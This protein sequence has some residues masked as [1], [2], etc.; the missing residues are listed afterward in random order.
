MFRY[1][2][3]VNNQNVYDIPFGENY[4]YQTHLWGALPGPGGTT[5]YYNGQTVTFAET[6]VGYYVQNQDR[7]G[8]YSG[9]IDIP[10][11]DNLYSFSIDRTY[12]NALAD[13]F[14]ETNGEVS[15][16]IPP[17]SSQAF[18][19]Y[20]AKAILSLSPRLNLRLANYLVDYS[21]HFTPDGGATWLIDN[22][23]VEAPRAALTYQFDPDTIVRASMGTSIAPPF[24][25][26]VTTQSGPPQGNVQG[27]PA[28]YVFTANTG[29][30]QPEVGFGYDIGADKRFGT[31]TLLS[32][33]LYLTTLHGQYLTSTIL[34]GTYT[35]VSPSPN[36]G[37]TAPLYKIQSQNLGLSR[38]EGIE[39]SLA[40]MPLVGL[41]YRIQGNIEKAFTYNLPAGIYQTA[42]S[43]APNTN[44]GLI[45]YINYR[46]SGETFNGLTTSN[47][48]YA[49]GYGEINYHWRSGISVLLGA[50]YYGNNNALD[51]PPFGVVNASL[52]VPLGNKKQTTLWLTGYNLTGAYNKAFSSIDG[53]IPVPLVNGQLGTLPGVTVGPAVFHLVASHQFG[54]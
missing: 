45:P 24:L 2:T 47:I 34:D 28:Y 53:G 33:D 23:T 11:G 40:K 38:F 31:D 12:H 16:S 1:Y 3:G 6:A 42:G 50:T 5:N 15:A 25:G 48:P 4:T 49:M 14:I 52:K 21:T 46:G 51:E 22:T 7:F 13:E 8:G 27:N 30:I 17:G 18:T 43:P 10:A 9:E 37:V 26:L 54:G 39:M 44:L 19:T 20:L 32:T 35:A 36:A 29:N 41:G